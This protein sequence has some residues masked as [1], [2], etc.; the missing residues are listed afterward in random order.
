M[1]PSLGNALVKNQDIT[2]LI[3]NLHILYINNAFNYLLSY[4]MIMYF[5][6]FAVSMQ[7]WIIHQHDQANVICANYHW[8][9]NL[10]SMNLKKSLHQY[11]LIHCLS[12]SSIFGFY[13]A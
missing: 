10:N 4:A 7:I 11:N 1:N 6:M 13:C 8:P 3:F 5:Y 9:W 12:Y 2:Y